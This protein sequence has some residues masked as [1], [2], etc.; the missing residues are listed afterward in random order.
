MPALLRHAACLRARR[1]GKIPGLQGPKG[2]PPGRM[3][4]SLQNG[5]EPNAESDMKKAKNRFRTAW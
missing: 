3:T 5:F 2:P 1:Q 4:L